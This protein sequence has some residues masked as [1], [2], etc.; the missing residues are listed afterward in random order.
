MIGLP[1]STI[2]INFLLNFMNKFKRNGY[3]I[4]VQNKRVGKTQPLN[5]YY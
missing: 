2:F 5:M 3:N 4:Q 1:K